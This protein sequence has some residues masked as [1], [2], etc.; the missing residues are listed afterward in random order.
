VTK[1]EIQKWGRALGRDQGLTGG[2]LSLCGK[3]SGERGIRLKKEKGRR[4]V[5]MTL[6]SK[7]SAKTPEQRPAANG[8]RLRE[9]LCTAPTEKKKEK[10]HFWEREGQD[11]SV[12][13]N[14]GDY[15]PGRGT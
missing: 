9:G 13:R 8:D 14:G 2:P 3:K 12:A 5:F 15:L 4:A 7:V 1:G 11:C 6:V 10:S